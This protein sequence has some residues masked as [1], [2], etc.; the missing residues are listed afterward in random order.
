MNCKAFHGAA[1]CSLKPRAL[2][3]SFFLSCLLGRVVEEQFLYPVIAG[4][5]IQQN[6]RRQGEIF[7]LFPDVSLKNAQAFPVEMLIIQV[8]NPAL[9]TGHVTLWSWLTHCHHTQAPQ[10]W[11]E[12]Q[13]NLTDFTCLGLKKTK[14]RKAAFLLPSHLGRRKLPMAQCY[15]SHFRWISISFIEQLSISQTRAIVQEWRKHQT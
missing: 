11:S 7:M 13:Q 15:S 3:L 9:S 5:V 4:T 2:L 1:G 14:L 10:A 12:S 6:Q 8:Q